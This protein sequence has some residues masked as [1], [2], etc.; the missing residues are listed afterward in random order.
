MQTNYQSGDACC[1]TGREAGIDPTQEKNVI[2]A[3][4]AC[5]SDTCGCAVSGTG[6]GG[7]RLAQVYF[8]DQTYRAGFCPCEAI[9]KGTLFPELVS[10]FT[11]AVS[12]QSNG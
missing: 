5:T 10:P 8:P 11:P 7:C 3:G 6:N 2:L 9:E 4:A 12:C 1:F